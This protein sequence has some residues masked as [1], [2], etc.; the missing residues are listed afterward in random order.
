MSFWK[1]EDAKSVEMIPG[2]TRQ[3]ISHGEQ[4]MAVRFEL[5]KGSSVPGHAHRYEQI[6]F[7]ITGRLEMT[8]GDESRLL[9]PGDG[10][11][12]PPHVTHGATAFDEDCVV[13]DVFT[14]LRE[15]Y[16]V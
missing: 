13:V 8:I 16:L 12:I 1:A 5:T 4:A 7:V 14:P 15:D 6:G 3:L 11:T 9:E 10:Y 2:V